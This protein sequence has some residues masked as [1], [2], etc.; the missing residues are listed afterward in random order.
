[1]S[2][3][4]WMRMAMIAGEKGR[5]GKSG[6]FPAVWRKAQVDRG[7]VEYPTHPR[8]GEEEGVGQSTPQ[9]RCVLYRCVYVPPA[10][11]TEN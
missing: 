11:S 2:L 8:W 5:G 7:G 4:Y 3:S 1:M 10:H 9:L 6:S